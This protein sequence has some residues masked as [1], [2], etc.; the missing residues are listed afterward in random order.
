MSD[1]QRKCLTAGG[2]IERRMSSLNSEGFK[3]YRIQHHI[4]STRAIISLDLSDNTTSFQA[5]D[6]KPFGEVYDSTTMIPRLSWRDAENDFE[7]SYTHMG[8][9][10][11]DPVLGRFFSVDPLFEAFRDQGVYNYAFNSP[12]NWKDPSGLAPVDEKGNKLLV[13]PNPS[14]DPNMLI[15]NINM[16]ED[17]TAEMIR[18]PFLA[19]KFLNLS[20]PDFIFEDYLDPWATY[21]EGSRLGDAGGSGG[22]SGGVSS[23]GGNSNDDDEETDPDDLVGK[24]L[25]DYDYD[26]SE[27]LLEEKSE[28]DLPVI[29]HLLGT[30]RGWFDGLLGSSDE[31]AIWNDSDED[32]WV[33]SEEG[34]DAA[35]VK[36]GEKHDDEIDGFASRDGVFKVTDGA[37]LIYKGDK[38]LVKGGDIGWITNS[39][40]FLHYSPG[41]QG[42]DFRNDKS[43]VKFR[44]LWIKYSKLERIYNYKD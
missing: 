27:T 9:R 13:A 10:Q 1:T 30:I 3:N 32:I 7:S 29:E 34:D 28:E 23:S 31:P 4:G 36:A 20:L 16:Q 12:V 24:E 11:Y 33:L 19:F 21:G 6:Y 14:F 25:E 8:A 43:T 39:V 17:L 18:D 35:I 5:F 22:S 41:W 38:V 40:S 37:T 44:I 2:A 26:N 15:D 42:L